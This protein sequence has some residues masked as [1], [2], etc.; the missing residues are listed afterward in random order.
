MVKSRGKSAKEHAM[1]TVWGYSQGG[2][3]VGGRH[4]GKIRSSDGGRV[5]TSHKKS[6][7]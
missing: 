7:Y 3:S 2:R 1:T 4:G 6:R 5:T